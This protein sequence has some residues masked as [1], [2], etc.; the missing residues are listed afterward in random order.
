MTL[1]PQQPSIEPQRPEEGAAEQWSPRR[2]DIFRRRSGS[3]GRRHSEVNSYRGETGHGEGVS[4]RL[5][6]PQQLASTPREML[7]IRTWSVFLLLI[8]TRS[9]SFFFAKNVDITLILQI[10][11]WSRWRQETGRWSPCSAANS[12][13]KA[14]HWRSCCSL[15]AQVNTIGF[16][17][18][19][20]C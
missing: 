3:G 17:T 16:W 18:L 5:D 13:P 7:Q 9:L 2:P 6:S 11:H 19:W 15:T 8:N 20:N 4:R 1:F 10:Q 14:S 12:P